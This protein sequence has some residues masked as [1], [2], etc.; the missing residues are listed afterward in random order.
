MI[1]IIKSLDFKNFGEE[2]KSWYIPAATRLDDGR[3]MATTQSVQGTDF[4]GEPMFAISSDEGRTW[5]APAPIPSLLS[6]KLQGTDITVAV[7]DIH[8][9]TSPIDG[10]VFAFGFTVY[11]SPKGNVCWDRDVE[12]TELPR[13]VGVYA[14][15]RPETGWSER[16]V[17]P[18][19]NH[20]MSYRTAATQ[21]AFM[22]DGSFLI[23]IYATVR[24]GTYCGYPSD[25][26]GVTAPI[27]RQ[28]GALLE[29]VR[30]GRILTHDAGRGFFEPSVVRLA[31]DSYAMTIRAEDR[32]MYVSTSADGAEWSEPRPWQWDDGTPLVTESTQQHWIRLADRTFLVFTMK[33]NGNDSIFRY[34]APLLVAE[35][36]PQKGLLVHSS[37]QTVF[38]RQRL[39]GTEAFYGNFHCAQLDGNTALVT[40]AALFKGNGENGKFWA[41]TTVMAARISI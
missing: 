8:P 37:L 17:L 33:Y 3:W 12:K 25:F 32:K 35:A 28:N 19:P 30:H 31:D 34:R 2:N 38:E 15:W 24:R 14:T 10:T 26:Y 21:L 13:E 20:G 9:F 23:P 27:Y 5:S 40:D 11:Y 22:P 36:I 39:N 16:K 29:H 1:P 6:E 4:Y 7:C 18:L 41:R